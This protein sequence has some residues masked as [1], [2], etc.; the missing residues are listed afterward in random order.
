[1]VARDRVRESSTERPRLIRCLFKLPAEVDG[2]G[3][4][5]SKAASHRRMSGI[6]L[7]VRLQLDRSTNV[8]LG[9]TAAGLGREV[10]RCVDQDMLLASWKSILHQPSMPARRKLHTNSILKLRSIVAHSRRIIPDAVLP[11]RPVVQHID[12]LIHSRQRH[13]RN[14][15]ILWSTASAA[16][17]HHGDARDL[18]VRRVTAV[19]RRVRDVC[20]I[21]I[22]ADFGDA[23]G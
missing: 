9:I 12:R 18:A 15:A 20:F 13:L 2:D 21:R 11:V 7:S 10:V 14:Q 3:S 5:F 19:D 23:K 16:L 1:M 6:S 4:A 22:D 8:E 17:M